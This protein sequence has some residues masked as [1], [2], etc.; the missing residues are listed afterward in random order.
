[1]FSV[2]LSVVGVLAEVLAGVVEM[3]ET[4]V[5]SS[6]FSVDLSGVILMSLVLVLVSSLASFSFPFSVSFFFSSSVLGLLLEMV[7][8]TEF[9]SLAWLSAVLDFGF[10]LSAFNAGF[11]FT[12]LETRV[13]NGFGL[14]SLT[15]GLL[16]EFVTFVLFSSF[17][18]VVFLSF[19]I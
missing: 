10:G 8:S 12:M 7:E 11:W 4:R 13:V 6:S 15:S 19:E 2:F 14:V 1:M 5:L 18:C 16:F 17:G 9:C 3:F